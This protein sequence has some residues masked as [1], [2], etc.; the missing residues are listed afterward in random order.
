[1]RSLLELI[2]TVLTIYIWVLII[3]AILSWLIA[4]NVINTYNRFVYSVAD[5]MNRLTEPLL[6]P[7][8]SFLPNLGGIDVSPVILIL[9][10]SFVRNLLQAESTT[11]SYT[12]DPTAWRAISV[13][14]QGLPIQSD[15][16]G[17]PGDT[18]RFGDG[19][20]GASPTDGSSLE[21]ANACNDRRN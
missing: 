3:Q 1:M 8:R 13:T 12:V 18:I 7:I 2:D 4:F 19:V 6:R 10:I 20:F 11:P 9:L 5:L 21:S 15:I 16:D 14:P 17:G